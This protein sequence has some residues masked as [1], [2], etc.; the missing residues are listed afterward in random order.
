MSPFHVIFFLLRRT[1]L[2]TLV[3]LVLLHLWKWSYYTRGN[4]LITLVEMV[5][6]HAWSPSYYTR[7]A[8]LI[9]RMEP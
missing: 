4:G 5:L 9:T 7:G 1:G 8:H 3:E 6:L 2:I